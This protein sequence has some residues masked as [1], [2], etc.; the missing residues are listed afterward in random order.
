MHE[1]IKECLDKPDDE[2]FNETLSSSFMTREAKNC[3]KYHDL[4][5]KIN[6]HLQGM[7]MSSINKLQ[8]RNLVQVFTKRVSD[9]SINDIF[10]SFTKKSDSR[11]VSRNDD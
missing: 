9:S 7:D 2:V 4:M 8:Y 10:N 5:R 3:L 1:A 6:K 11:N